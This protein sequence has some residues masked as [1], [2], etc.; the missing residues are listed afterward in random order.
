MNTLSWHWEGK[1]DPKELVLRETELR[2]LGEDEIV[3]QNTAIGLNPVDWKLIRSAHPAWVNGHVPGVDGAG[4]VIKTGSNMTHIPI[5]TRICYH[6]NLSKNGSFSTETIIDGRKLMFIPPH[7]S[8]Y[9]AAAFPC[10]SL[11]AWQAV[12][13]IPI[14]QNL[15]V[16]VNGAGG[17]LGYLLTQL[18]LEQGARVYVTASVKHHQ[19]LHQTGVINAFD[20]KNTGWKAALQEQM[21]G[22]KL[23]VV[24][25]TV[26]G[27]SASL[28]V[29]L[30]GY[31]GH[32]VSI[33]D[34]IATNPLP[35][36]TTCISLH[37]IALGAFHEFASDMQVSQLM[38]EGEKL[39]FKI[40]QGILKQ[41]QLVLGEFEHLNVILQ[42]MKARNSSDKYVI[43]LT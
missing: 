36:F 21:G 6:A 4:I 27:N 15:D 19:E 35:A 18:L 28:L 34:R 26:S 29:D 23:D 40:G 17:S 32:V 1:S 7:V 33:Q 9:A 5:G 42:E 20:Y 38:A 24:F 39:L 13:K 14:L 41:R 3:V 30:L 11:T 12:Q 16:L 2:S 22:K 10:P 43:K 37:E 25:D 8:D 31:Y